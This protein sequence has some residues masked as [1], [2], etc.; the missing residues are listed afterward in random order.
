MINST[1]LNLVKLRL[2]NPLKA[3][4]LLKVLDSSREMMRRKM[5]NQKL[6]K[7]RKMPKTRRKMLKMRRKM[8]KTRKKMKRKMIRKRKK[9]MTRTK[10][11]STPHGQNRQRW[12]KYSIVYMTSPMK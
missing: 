6:K 9:R 11:R 3:R 5:P 12:K 4:Q 7:K 1:I 2:K 10:K 8:P